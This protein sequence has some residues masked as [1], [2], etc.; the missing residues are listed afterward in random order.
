MSGL[1]VYDSQYGNTQKVAEAVGKGLSGQ[2]PC[3]LVHIDR[4][5]KE[6][7]AGITFLIVGSPTQGFSAT[8]KVKMWLD[9]LPAN[10]LKG[11]HAAAFDTRFTPEKINEVGILSLLVSVFGYG[12][13]PIAKRLTKKGAELAGEPVGFYVSDTE[14]PLLDQELERAASWAAQLRTESNSG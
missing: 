8:A 12:A 3:K 11:I 10:R 5:C 13:K 4:I 9:S 7:L 2:E 14:G 1:V 6:D